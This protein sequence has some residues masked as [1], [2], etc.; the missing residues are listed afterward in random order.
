MDV[1][2]LLDL[3]AME[4]ETKAQRGCLPKTRSLEGAEAGS[5]FRECQSGPESLEDV[6]AQQTLI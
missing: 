4:G 3:T 6:H 2:R 1:D 5:E